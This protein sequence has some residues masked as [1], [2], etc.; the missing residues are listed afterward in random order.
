MIFPPIEDFKPRKRMGQKM[1]E[2]RLKR[3]LV[4][5]KVCHWCGCEV[6]KGEYDVPS[7]SNTATSDHVVSHAEG[8]SNSMGNLVLACYRCNQERGKEQ[9]FWIKQARYHAMA[10]NRLFGV[11]IRNG[12]AV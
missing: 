6:V 10:P 11:F 12:E 7:A 1:Q 3:L 4:R 5:D 2:S 8:G 9:G